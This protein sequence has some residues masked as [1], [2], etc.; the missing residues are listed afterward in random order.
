MLT[1]LVIIFVIGYLAIA[2]EHPLKLD[3]TASA[4]ITGML[5]WTIIALLGSDHSFA[6]PHINQKILDLGFRGFVEHSLVEHLFGITGILFFLLGAMTI[7]EVID[8]NHGFAL[9]TEK[10]KTTN[11]KKLLFIVSFATFFISA[12]LDNL[13][14]TIIMV[15]LIMKL[16]KS[17][18]HQIIYGSMIVIAANAGGAWTVIGDVTTTMLWIGGQISPVNVMM[19]LLIP[20]LICLLVP[21]LI[22]SYWPAM[23]GEFERVKLDSP[24]HSDD[25]SQTIVLILGI[26]SFIFV[27]IFKSVTHLPPFVGMLLSLGILWSV[28][29]F[30]HKDKVDEHKYNLSV[31]R[32][33]KKIDTSSILFFLGILMAVSALETSGI[34]ADLAA[35]LGVITSN[36]DIIAVVIGLLSSIIDNVPLVAA[37]MGMYSIAPDASSIFAMDGKFWMMMAYCAG[38]GGSILIIGSAAG[39]AAMSLLKIEFMW[40][41]KRIGWVAMCGY[42]AGVIAYLLI[43]AATHS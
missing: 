37:S 13:T 9:I 42:F 16:V 4:L 30:L 25:A 18:E 11:K 12:I 6:E 32:A 5:C 19:S 1:I 8:I 39:I 33:L 35:K 20:S 31:T 36:Y 21:L 24:T 40:Y 26:A 34:L 27:P 38:T 23:K 14:T 2:L 41:M 29:E 3:K 7:V 43:Y 17:R 28:L 10:I 22:V 15:S